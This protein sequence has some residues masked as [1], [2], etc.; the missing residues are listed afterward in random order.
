[1][2]DDGYY[3]LPE[4][5]AT[6]LHAS[7]TKPAGRDE[8]AR[9]LCKAWVTAERQTDRAQ[10]EVGKGPRRCTRCLAALGNACD[11]GEISGPKA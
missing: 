4:W 1:M 9:A 10:R 3:W 5:C 8:I 7:K 2:S 11:Q 6:R